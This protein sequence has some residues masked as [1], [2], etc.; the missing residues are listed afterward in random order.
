MALNPFNSS[1]L[2]QLALKGLMN[3]GCTL[4]WA[5]RSASRAIFAVAELLVITLP[6]IAVLC[7]YRHKYLASTTL[8][9]LANVYHQVVLQMATL[10]KRTFTVLPT[11]LVIECHCR[12]I[13]FIGHTPYYLNFSR[14]SRTATCME[15]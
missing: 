2:E 13:I 1:N 12:M 8:F 9:L 6:S 3:E 11:C 7:I 5:P 15:S 4:L 14:L 10:C